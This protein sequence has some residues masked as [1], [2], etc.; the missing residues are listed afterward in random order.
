MTKDSYVPLSLIANFKSLVV[1]L[2]DK[3]MVHY[4]NEPDR[5]P[6]MIDVNNHLTALNPDVPVFNPE[7]FGRMKIKV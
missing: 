6:L 2:N 3:C 5:W 4:R 7:K 1:E